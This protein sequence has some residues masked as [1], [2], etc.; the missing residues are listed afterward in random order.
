MD[1]A[2][3]EYLFKNYYRYSTQRESLK[4]Q[5]EILT[6]RATK[7]TASFDAEKISAAPRDN[8]KPSKV[9]RYAIKIV[10]AKE[11][12]KQL[13]SL[14]A[15]GDNLFASLRPHQ[16][17]LVRCVVCNGM[18]PEDFSRREGIKPLTVKH[19]LDAIYKK[20]ESSE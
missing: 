16:R 4:E 6:A 1:R 5:I 9:E 14:I 3:I 12:I 17:Y 2:E 20:L 15:V 8:P 18:K 10:N 19:N 11:K 7:I 13:D